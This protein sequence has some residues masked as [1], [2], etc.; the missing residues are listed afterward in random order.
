MY[1]KLIKRIWSRLLREIKKRRSL[2]IRK[3]RITLGASNTRKGNVLVAYR[4]EHFLLKPGEPEST[5]HTNYWESYQIAKTFSDLGYSVDVIDN[6]NKMFIPKKEY[7]IFVCARTNF[8]R[9]ALRLNKD[10]IKIV[11]LDTAH[12]IFNN[13]ATYRR[14]LNFQQRKGVTLPSASL[15]VLES[16]L[17]IEYANYATILGNQFT[18]DTYHYTQKPIYPVPIPA[19]I[20]YP[21]SE[22]KNYEACRKNYLFF[23]SSSFIHKGLDLVLDAFAEMPDYHLYICGPIHNEKDFEKF[24]YQ[25]LYHTPNIHTAGWV[26]VGSSRFMEI[27]NKC[28]GLVYPSCSEGQAGSVIN[29]LHAGLIPVISYESG[30]NID[31]FGIILKECSIEEIK[32]SVKKISGIPAH[33]LKM[34]AR[35]AWEFARANHTRERYAKEYRKVIVNIIGENTQSGNRDKRGDCNVM[36]NDMTL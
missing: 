11:H 12:W 4:I 24:Y 34:M 33:D 19:C 26:E 10:C 25:E 15:R 8:V 29:C 17:A 6:L 36:L 23:S 7:L 21:W 31:D 9:T 1:R 22:D 2:K 3:T 13:Y 35:K 16:N 27:M 32:N 5:A 20:V 30:V 18:M 14:S 28:I